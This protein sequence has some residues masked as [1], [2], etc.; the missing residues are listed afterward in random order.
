MKK[1]V[2]TKL[3]AK[4]A[5][6]SLQEAFIGLAVIA[7]RSLS[8]RALEIVLI[9]LFSVGITVH[10]LLDPTKLKT[11]LDTAFI[12]K[13]LVVVVNITLNCQ[14][15]Q[16]AKL[17]NRLHLNARKVLIVAKLHTQKA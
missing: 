2:K 3:S 14:F 1:E 11:T 4:A 9:H 13:D 6:S 10:E 12:Q 15:H 8:P 7:E 16:F 5:D 17:R